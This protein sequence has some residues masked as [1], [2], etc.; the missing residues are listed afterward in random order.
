[1][2]NLSSSAVLRRAVCAGQ[3]STRKKMIRTA[4]AKMSAVTANASGHETRCGFA[5][6]N[7][8]RLAFDVERFV[9]R[10]NRARA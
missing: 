4:M 7:I 10:R 3:L 8:R 1:L 6:F 2:P 5:E 9:S